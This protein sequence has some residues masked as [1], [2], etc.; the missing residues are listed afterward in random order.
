MSNVF[1]GLNTSDKIRG[2]SARMKDNKWEVKELAS[3]ARAY[4]IEPTDLI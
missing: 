1:E 2:I 4:D 3:I